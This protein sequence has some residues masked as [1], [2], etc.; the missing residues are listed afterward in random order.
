[1][2][3]LEPI[4]FAEEEEPTD[5]NETLILWT[6]IIFIILVTIEAGV[7]GMIPT[8]SPS[9]RENPKILGIAN[10]FAGGVILAIAFMHITPE[11]IETW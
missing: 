9:C 11:M 6:K 7:A 10:S 5:E 8:W 3:K 2:L 4:V 1:M